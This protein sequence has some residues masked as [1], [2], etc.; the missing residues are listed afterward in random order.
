MAER[1]QPRRQVRSGGVSFP[2]LQPVGLQAPRRTDIGER[3]QRS[4]I[5]ANR[6]TMA[7]QAQAASDLQSRIDQI[8]NMAFQ[9]AVPQQQTWGAEY[10]VDKAPTAKLIKN[11]EGDWEYDAN[12][13]PLPGD[14]WSVFGRAARKAALDQM[15]LELNLQSTKAMSGITTGALDIFGYPTKSPTEVKKELD[16]VV[17]DTHKATEGFSPALSAKLYASLRVA[18]HSSWTAYNNKWLVQQGKKGVAMAESA[19]IG[20]GDEALTAIK[21]GHLHLLPYLYAKATVAAAQSGVNVKSMDAAWKT[22]IQNAIVANTT[23]RA[24]DIGLSN[25]LD[26]YYRHTS[27]E[28]FGEKG[29]KGTGSDEQ[30]RQLRNAWKYMDPETKGKFLT[31]LDRAYNLEVGKP[32]TDRKAFE[33][34]EKQRLAGVAAEFWGASR[35]AQELRAPLMEAALSRLGNSEQAQTLREKLLKTRALQPDIEDILET[36]KANGTLTYEILENLSNQELLLGES[37]GKY[38]KHV[39]DKTKA[40]GELTT[41]LT[42]IKLHLKVVPREYTSDATRDEDRKALMKHSEYADMITMWHKQGVVGE[43]GK[44][45]GFTPGQKV[46]DTNV[47]SF[48]RQLVGSTKA[49]KEAENAFDE[50]A[51]AI[52]DP[53]KFAAVVRMIRLAK[54]GSDPVAFLEQKVN[55]KY[56]P[57]YKLGLGDKTEPALDD[58][59]RTQVMKWIAKY[60]AIE[61]RQTG[62]SNIRE[63]V[64]QSMRGGSD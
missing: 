47:L 33:A 3:A 31:E 13:Q 45:Y 5:D 61:S 56:A 60:R 9:T 54:R 35:A 36:H 42:H 26:H 48:A 15:Y 24:A 52:M 29:Q 19:I 51:G 34:K 57:W 44:E 39:G 18:G 14:D 46:D 40:S 37:L 58:A 1:R 4:N 7:M 12:G 8:T 50:A 62:K 43:D 41:A 11:A 16:K 27:L 20:Y 22:R 63:F 55:E 28:R 6:R 49:Q 64:Q 59:V 21:A 53:Q 23:L 10:G 17:E 25:V 32:I 38:M 30:S 2:S